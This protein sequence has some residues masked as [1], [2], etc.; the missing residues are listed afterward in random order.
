M[1]TTMDPGKKLINSVD[2]C[3][4]DM[5]KGLVSCHPGLDLHEKRRVVLVKE[6]EQRGNKVA[7]VS[8]GGSGHEPFSAGYVGEGMLTAVSAGS[9]FASPP[10]SSV[11]HAIKCVSVNNT[12]GV[13]VI[14]PNYTG[15][16][17]NF[18]LAVEWARKRE[19][20][21]ETI[22]VGE[23]CAISELRNSKPPR[24]RGMCGLVFTFKIG[25]AMS[26][27]GNTLTEIK[28]ELTKVVNSMATI[29]VALSACS[30]P[31]SPPLFT[32]APDE[33]ELGLGVHGEAGASRIKMCSASEAVQIMLDKL[34][35]TL[36]LKEGDEV[37]ALINNLGGSSHIE[38]WIIA[39][40]VI[41]QLGSKNINVKRIYVGALMTSLDMLGM[42]VCLLRL[43]AGNKDKWLRY[44]DCET[45][46][47]AWPGTKLSL[48]SHFKPQ[49]SESD[50]EEHIELQE[51]GLILGD[52][53]TSVFK[54]CLSAA[55]NAI[56]TAEKHLNELDS[57]CGD[58]DC[59]STLRR[60]AEGIL[61][62]IEKSSLSCPG[63]VFLQLANV[64]E[65]RMGGTSG[66]V[67]SLM[68]ISAGAKLE[69]SCLN[70]FKAFEEAWKCALEGV[71]KYS[72]AREGDR[73]MLDALIPA[74]NTYSCCM[75]ETRSDQIK[76]LMAAIDAAEQGC[77]NTQSMKARAG[78]AAYVNEALLTDV[79]AGA[80]G[81]ALWLKAVCSVLIEKLGG[82]KA[83][84]LCKSGH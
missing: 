80:H 72:T 75:K 81:V 36:S 55:S 21:V 56:I 14:I 5:L 35:I 38:E 19:I 22:T 66:A 31:G 82:E 84:C 25:G 69:D 42:Q 23:D 54:E 76:A 67:Y 78:R 29:G 62:E 41:N 74:Y 20:K 60:L 65:S 33:M 68:F 64:A 57:G 26:G 37:A 8:G 61:D 44:L 12:G 24:S 17:L 53:E 52:E 18:G 10:A 4:D 3:V 32:L 43:D 1:T 46:A 51:K 59:G 39:N 40:E 45:N 27:E 7:L 47:P 9:V 71:M 77:L 70:H 16:C 79:D 73:T 15:D 30:L 58:G 2:S 34:I 11:L 28:N 48:P 6:W 49:N 13:L 63:K 50:I 83:K